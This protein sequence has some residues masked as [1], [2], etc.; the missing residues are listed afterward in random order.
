MSASHWSGH[1]R[2]PLRIGLA[3]IAALVFLVEVSSLAGYY[4][5]PLLYVPRN[6]VL[7]G[8]IPPNNAVLAVVY[9]VGLV[10][11]TGVAFDRYPVRGGLLALSCMALVCEWGLE[12]FDSP[13]H[14]FFFPGGLLLGWIAGLGCASEILR[15]GTVRADP[16]AFREE[17]AEAG[18][19][20]VL[21]A[22]YVGSGVSKLLAA[23]LG[24]ADTTSLRALILAQRGVGFFHWVDVYRDVLVQHPRLSQAFAVATL[25]VELG[26]AFMLV[27]ARMRALWG[28]LLLGMHVN[29]FILCDIPYVEPMALLPLFTLPW[30]LLSRSARRGAPREVEPPAI[31]APEE[32]P[33]RVLAIVAVLLIAAWVLP[34]RWRG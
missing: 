11:L 24:W 10:G 4:Q 32:L 30:P 28:L 14:N 26:A 5:N 22:L 31:G 27:S 8:L 17:L 7:V 6:A 15:R 12:L 2:A 1:S 19:V 23:G 3:I 16:R 13:S 29:I 34:V 33:P 20:G 21:A 18:A 9:L 25:V